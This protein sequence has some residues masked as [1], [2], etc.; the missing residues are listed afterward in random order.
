MKKYILDDRCSTECCC[1][2]TPKTTI[3]VEIKVNCTSLPVNLSFRVKL[4]EACKSL[5]QQLNKIQ[6]VATPIPCEGQCQ[7]ISDLASFLVSL[8][9]WLGQMGT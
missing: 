6:L 5:I 3:R 4:L 9:F 2:G 1:C 8:S 7:R